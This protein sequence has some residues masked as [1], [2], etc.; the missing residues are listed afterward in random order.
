MTVRPRRA[1]R[2]AGGLLDDRSP[3]VSSDS[4]SLDFATKSGVLERRGRILEGA[5]GDI[6]DR[7]RPAET[8]SVT[9][10]PGRT[11]WPAT[12]SAPTT[13]PRGALLRTSWRLRQADAVQAGGRL[14][15]LRPDEIGGHPHQRRLGRRRG[16]GRARRRAALVRVVGVEGAER[17][18]GDRSDRDQQ[19]H[20]GR[21]RASS[22]AA[23]GRRPGS[24][25]RGRPRGRHDLRDL[26]RGEPR[27]SARTRALEVVGHRRRARI[28]HARIL[29]ERPQHHLL[30]AGGIAGLSRDGGGGCSETCFMAIATAESPSN[31]T[32]P[33]SIS[34]STTPSE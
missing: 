27:L 2:S 25:G 11:S 32:R 31:G 6:D 5:P 29:G 13:S 17:E 7:G 26:A 28:A 9:S 21:S 14:L 4:T 30:D 22:C 18:R 33:V 15:V 19:H 34:Y 12:G 1:S 24:A 10:E 8:L 23:A 3:G 16:R 20:D